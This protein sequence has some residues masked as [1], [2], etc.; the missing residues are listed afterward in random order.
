MESITSEGS[1]GGIRG[2]GREP[3]G[4]ECSKTEAARIGGVGAQFDKGEEERDG[5]T[6]LLLEILEAGLEIERGSKSVIFPFTF[7]YF[8]SLPFTRPMEEIGGG[9]LIS[10]I[11]FFSRSLE[12]ERVIIRV[13]AL[14]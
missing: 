6:E 4:S 13:E 1:E 3:M 11:F 9:A 12:E 14:E 2:T 7:L 5:T 8:P 10:E